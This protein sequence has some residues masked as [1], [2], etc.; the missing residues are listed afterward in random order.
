MTSL[1]AKSNILGANSKIKDK[2]F[3]E[4]LIIIFVKRYYHPNNDW[5]MIVT[6]NVSNSSVS[7]KCLIKICQW[8]N[9]LAFLSER[10]HQGKGSITLAPDDND[11]KPFS[12]VTDVEII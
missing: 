10:Q 4:M 2:K 12:L 3:T 11:L 6:G 8:Q 5:K 7:N 9:T 1:L